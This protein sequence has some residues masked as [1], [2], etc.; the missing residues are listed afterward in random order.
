MVGM[1]QMDYLKGR[2][3]EEIQ[4]IL[5]EYEDYDRR[6]SYRVNRVP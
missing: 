5:K 2:P 6:M 3:V 1:S 4:T